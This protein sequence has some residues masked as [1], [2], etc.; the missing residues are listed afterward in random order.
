VIVVL[1]DIFQKSNSSAASVRLVTSSDFAV[2]VRII[3]GNKATIG[4]FRTLHRQNRTF[5]VMD[6]SMGKELPPTPGYRR[7]L[8]QQ[9][10]AGARSD[11]RVDMKCWIKILLVIND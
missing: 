2:V 3:A 4:Y 8:C 1:L 7:D 6:F 11:L 5:E 9:F 10:D